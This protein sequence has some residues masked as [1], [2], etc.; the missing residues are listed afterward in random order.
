M[1]E[2]NQKS[3]YFLDNRKNRKITE[4]TEDRRI[5]NDR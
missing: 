1:T 2:N 5:E 4:I 3:L